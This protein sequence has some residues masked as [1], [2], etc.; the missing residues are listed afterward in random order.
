MYPPSRDPGRAPGTGV[1]S[2][3]VRYGKGLAIRG[4]TLSASY[5]EGEDIPVLTE[6]KNVSRD[7]MQW[8]V[9]PNSK[10]SCSIRLMNDNGELLKGQ[11]IGTGSA[12]HVI[13]LEPGEVHRRKSTMQGWPHQ[14]GRVPAGR[15]CI[16]GFRPLWA[17]LGPRIELFR[18]PI[19]VKSRE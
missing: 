6:L 16:V 18:I 4:G 5:L 14:V 10:G 11:M 3:W 12:C 9:N 19:E 15:Y 1:R 17:R 13:T 8:T 7:A 2:E